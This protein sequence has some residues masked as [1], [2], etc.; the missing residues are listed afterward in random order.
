MLLVN[1][2][3]RGCKFCIWANAELGSAAHALRDE[4]VKLL[5]LESF[6]GRRGGAAAQDR[7]RKK[8]MSSSEAGLSFLGAAPEP[9]NDP[10]KI[11][12]SRSRPVLGVELDAVC[13][14]DTCWRSATA[15]RL[16]AR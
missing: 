7:A 3:T 10:E 16:R 1:V 8:L 5:K 11:P 12:M 6:W 15:S 9:D 13:E 2:L 4:D 14:L